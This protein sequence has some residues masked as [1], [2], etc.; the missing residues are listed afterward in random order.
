[1]RMPAKQPVRQLL[2]AAA[3]DKTVLGKGWHRAATAACKAASG[4]LG[5]PTGRKR[6]EDNKVVNAEMKK[7][8]AKR[9]TKAKFDKKKNRKK[10][11]SVFPDKVHAARTAKHGHAYPA[12]TARPHTVLGYSMMRQLSSSAHFLNGCTHQGEGETRKHRKGC[13]HCGAAVESEEHALLWCPKLEGERRIFLETTGWP[14]DG[15]QLAASD[16]VLWMVPDARQAKCS[17]EEMAT[18]VQE[19]CQSIAW[20]RSSRQAKK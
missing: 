17:E 13:V 14:R 19:F 10:A 2:S 8:H 9:A 20:T 16:A 11:Q 6:W 7:M 15:T 5:K 4:A 1:M 18:A 3:A 12:G